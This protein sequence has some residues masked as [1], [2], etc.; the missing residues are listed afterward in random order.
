MNEKV[1]LEVANDPTKTVSNAVAEIWGMS[2]KAANR[3]LLMECQRGIR[4]QIGNGGH[5]E[6]GIQELTYEEAKALMNSLRR[7]IDKKKA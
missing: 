1:F 5:Y 6:E 2:P 7:F 3:I 4:I